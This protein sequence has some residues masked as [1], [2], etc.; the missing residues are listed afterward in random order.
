MGG[1][2]RGRSPRRG[3]RGGRGGRGGRMSRGGARGGKK[4]VPT[5]EELDAELDAYTFQANK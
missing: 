1:K 5:A 4:K 3:L 2:G